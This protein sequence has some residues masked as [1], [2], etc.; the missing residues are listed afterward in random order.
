MFV[1]V[2][3]I[4][5]FL[6]VLY[7]EKKMSGFKHQ[8]KGI[9]FYSETVSEDTAAT[10]VVDLGDEPDELMADL[11]EKE[12]VFVDALQVPVSDQYQ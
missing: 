8:S 12:Q 5:W 6:C 2:K 11:S 1:Y 9:C 7:S 10:H 4:R 3:S